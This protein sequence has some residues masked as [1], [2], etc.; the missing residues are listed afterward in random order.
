M[1]ELAIPRVEKG[2]IIPPSGKSS[3]ILVRH[4]AYERRRDSD[5]AGSL[6]KD[7]AEEASN[8]YRVLFDQLFSHENGRQTMV[9]F[10]ASGTRYEKGYRCMETAQLAEDAAIEVLQTEGLDPREH[11]I[12]LNP[13][14]KT[15][16]FED[17]D[18]QIR[19]ESQLEEPRIFENPEYIAYLQ[20]KYG[21]A[22]GHGGG[23]S[24]D[25]WAAHERDAEPEAREQYGAEGV[26]DVVARTKRSLSVM[27]RYARV[28]HANNPGKKLVIFAV[29][30]YDTISPLVKDTTR[31]DF[32]EYVPVDYGGGVV[33]NM[34]GE[35][36]P[37]LE[38]QDK[39]VPLSL[40]RKALRS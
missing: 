27:D 26:H 38:A 36:D 3:I 9:L 34:G 7:T 25:A 17:T 32:D 14:F 5:G 40:G 10:V 39:S 23:L 33:I 29:S 28:F 19:P 18:Q 4:E 2:D 13:Q 12:N 1:S 11:I 37:T 15:N 22:D 24:R 31:V 20:G 8:R 35:T 21:S 30:H 16:C 6:L